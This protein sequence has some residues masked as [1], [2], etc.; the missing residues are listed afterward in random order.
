MNSR[1]P[2]RS[3]LLHILIASF[4]YP[5]VTQSCILFDT[6]FPHILQ[7]FIPGPFL[8]LARCM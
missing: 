2:S 7:A 8:S 1:L 5:Y 4:V 3:L 6:Q